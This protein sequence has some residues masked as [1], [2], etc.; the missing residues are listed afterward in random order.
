MAERKL[1]S[2]V[3]QCNAAL[4]TALDFVVDEMELDDA[5]SSSTSDS[6]Q[7]TIDSDNDDIS[8]LN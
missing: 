2:L 3:D 6:Q 8:L 7:V 4:K 1:D 5:P